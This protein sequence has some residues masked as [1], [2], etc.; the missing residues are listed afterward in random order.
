MILALASVVNYDRQSDAPI[1]SIT[2]S[3]VNYDRN[4]FIIQATG[5][6]YFSPI[7]LSFFKPLRFSLIILTSTRVLGY[8]GTRVLG[9]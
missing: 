8:W 7:S 1:W 2:S 4:K 6:I 3:G 9:Y 5:D